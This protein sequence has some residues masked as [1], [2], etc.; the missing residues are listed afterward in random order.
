METHTITKIIG[1]RMFNIEVTKA[2]GNNETPI[3]Q[4]FCPECKSKT[5]EG[6]VDFDLE[7][8]MQCINCNYK[9]EAWF[10]P[11]TLKGSGVYTAGGHYSNEPLTSIPLDKA[12]DYFFWPWHTKFYKV[13][14]YT[15]IHGGGEPWVVGSLDECIEALNTFNTGINGLSFSFVFPTGDRESY[16]KLEIDTNSRARNKEIFDTLYKNKEKIE[17]DFGNQLKWERLDGKKQSQ[18]IYSMGRKVPFLLGFGLDEEMVNI[19]V[20]FA[21]AIKPHIKAFQLVEMARTFKSFETLLQK[22]TKHNEQ[23]I[24]DE[25]SPSTEMR[26]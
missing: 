4:F 10:F 13:K 18:I 7:D 21:N 2:R 1:D 11:H 22:K 20:K 23:H 5:Y 26:F 14:E 19:M 12:L 6:I 9:N 3:L 25:S 15:P 17:A 24:F 16:I 8:E